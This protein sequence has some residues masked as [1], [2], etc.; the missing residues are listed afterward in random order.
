MVSQV[1]LGNFYS[2]NGKTVVGGAGG[3]GIDTEGLIKSLTDAKALPATK[4]EDKI[5]L[6][7]KRS[8]ALTEMKDLIDRFRDAANFLRNPPGVSNDTDNVFKHVTSGVTSNT[9]ITGSTYLTVTAT[10]GSDLR[11]YAISV[12]TLAKATKQSTGVISIATAD[13][14]AVFAAP[15]A[16]QFG[17]GIIVVNG[18]TITL[19]DGDSLNTVASKFNAV[20]DTSGITASV[21]KITDGSFKLLYSAT[22]T[23]TTADFDLETVGTVSSDPSGALAQI[24]FTTEQD[25]TNAQFIIDGITITRQ[26]NSIDDVIDGVTFNLLQATPALTTL[27]VSLKP[28]AELVKSGII[29]FVNVYNDFRTF[30]AKQTQ[31]KSDGTTAEDSVL[32]NNPT[33][34]TAMNNISAKMATIVS[35]VSSSPNRLSD[36]G[37]TSVDLPA[38]DEA[39]LVRNAYT[40]D[41]SKLDAAIAADF[42]GVRD[43][44]EF[45]E[46]SSN[47]NVR[48]FSRTNSLAASSLTLTLTPSTNTF[49][50]TYNN[51]SGPVTVSLDYTALTGGGYKLSGQSSTVFE[52]LVMIYGSSADSTSTMTLTQGV[53]DLVYNLTDDLLERDTGALDSELK[54]IADANT[55]LQKNIDTINTQVEDYRTQL[56]KKFGE[57]EAAIS[58]VNSLLTNLQAQADARNNA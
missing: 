53:G 47:S 34:R 43:V 33:L 8:T 45:Q 9:S 25:A 48:V 18:A 50:A 23:G 37:I 51:G 42:A 26:G 29:N 24:T 32:A 20:S 35:G 57:M 14:Q 6:N 28:D 1:T 36:L 44:F 7:E 12:T 49:Q 46:T 41:E 52:G 17:A 31:V 30:Y 16:S 39:P 4:L 22:A 19:A 11:D 2:A 13:S 3:S 10:P 21:I 27:T 56:L 58:R 5:T 55:Q 40:L 54:S 38:T 15:A